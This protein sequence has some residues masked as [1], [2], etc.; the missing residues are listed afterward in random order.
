MSIEND[1]SSETI[2]GFLDWLGCGETTDDG[3]P[4]MKAIRTDGWR[5]YGP[6]AKSKGLCAKYIGVYLQ[7][8]KEIY[9]VK[10]SLSISLE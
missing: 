4:L 1:P 6:A 8:K 5:S 3:K 10:G 7:F 2:G 9:Y